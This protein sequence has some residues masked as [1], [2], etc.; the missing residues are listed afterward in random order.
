MIFWGLMCILGGF[1]SLVLCIDDR[2]PKACIPTEAEKAAEAKRKEKLHAEY[3]ANERSREDFAKAVYL[4]T[5][6]G[7][8]VKNPKN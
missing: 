5:K 6:E 1:F 4:L 2:P 7:S 8:S 3:E